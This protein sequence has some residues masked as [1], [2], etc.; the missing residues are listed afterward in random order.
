MGFTDPGTVRP[1]RLVLPG[2][3][4]FRRYRYPG[5]VLSLGCLRWSGTTRPARGVAALGRAVTVRLSQ[6]FGAGRDTRVS[7]GRDLSAEWSRVDNHRVGHI[8]AA[9]GRS[10]GA[11]WLADR[12]H[13]GYDHD[14]YAV[15]LGRCQINPDL[16]H[17]QRRSLPVRLV[18]RPARSC[19]LGRTSRI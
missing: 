2:R 13:H 16:P 18:L 10:A 8:F 12:T 4:H 5:G 15:A 7:L 3:W 19:L 14:Y 6:H 17:S 9:V 11:N 1:V